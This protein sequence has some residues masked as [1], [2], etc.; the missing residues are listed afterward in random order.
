MKANVMRDSC[1]TSKN[2]NV[3]LW[4]SF[5]PIYTVGPLPFSSPFPTGTVGKKSLEE[6]TVFNNWVWSELTTAAILVLVQM[7]VLTTPESCAIQ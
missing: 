7:E 6:F 2:M 3:L 4:L 1:I 5:W